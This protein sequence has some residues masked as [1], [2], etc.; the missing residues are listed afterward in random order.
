MFE[1]CRE[2]RVAYEDVELAPKVVP[3]SEKRKGFD[4]SSGALCTRGSQ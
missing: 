2:G 1:I 4:S 3:H